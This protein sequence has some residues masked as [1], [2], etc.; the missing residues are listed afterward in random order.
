VDVCLF[1]FVDVFCCN[2]PTDIQQCNTDTFFYVN[3]RFGCYMY[4]GKIKTRGE[5]TDSATH[6]STTST[7]STTTNNFDIGDKVEGR[8]VDSQWYSGEIMG[9]KVG[10]KGK[11]KTSYDVKFDSGGLLYVVLALLCKYNNAKTQI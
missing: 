4:T 1:E 5:M 6:T 8:W 7:A 2:I 11:G 9:M 3:N 10:R